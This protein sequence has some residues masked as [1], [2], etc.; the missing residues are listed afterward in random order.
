MNPN[1]SSKR[2]VG[3]AAIAS[4]MGGACWMVKGSAILITGD[5]PPLLFEIAPA[6]FVLGLLGLYLLLDQDRSRTVKA[7]GIAVALAAALAFT[8]WLLSVTDRSTG[9]EERF[10]PT[11]LLAFIALFTGL[12]LLGLATRRDRALG[13]GWSALPLALAAGIPVMMVVGGLL[14][15]IDERLL[16]VPLVLYGFGW[17]GLGYALGRSRNRPPL[18]PIEKTTSPLPL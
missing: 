17:V 4:A 11:L 8:T 7:G 14:E 16:E 18:V 15:A 1:A 9:S 13:E 2:L 12:L 3:V 5:Q 6:F 10:Q